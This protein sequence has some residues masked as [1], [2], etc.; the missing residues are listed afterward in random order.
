MA[1]SFNYSIDKNFDHTIDEKGN[2]FISLRKIAWGNSEN[3]KLD[4]RKYY[5]T[6]DG[7]RMSRGVSFLTD[8]GPNELTNVLV[9]EG[10]GD[11]LELATIIKEN[12]SGVMKYLASDLDKIKENMDSD[13][14]LYDVRELLG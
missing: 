5:A 2:A 10:Y 8:D 11:D 9:Q 6:A 12:R 14:D 1:E 13:D 3:Y 4:L 7:E